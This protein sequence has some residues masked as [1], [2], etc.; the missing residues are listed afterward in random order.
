[1]AELARLR[2]GAAPRLTMVDK[3]ES[4]I[5]AARTD[6]AAWAILPLEGGTA[7]WARL[8]AEPDLRCFAVLPC[9]AAWGPPA[10]LAVAAVQ[11]EPSGADQTLWITDSGRRLLHDRRPS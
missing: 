9:L 8:L 6:L 3:P 11:V 2:F 7:P 4:A 1:M 5:A 10:A